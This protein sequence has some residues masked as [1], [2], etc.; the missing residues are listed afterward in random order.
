MNDGGSAVL[1]NGAFE[2][3][4]G[5]VTLSTNGVVFL[6]S[7][8]PVAASDRLEKA[9]FCWPYLEGRWI[10]G[11]QTKSGAASL[12]W[13][14]SILHGG[15]VGEAEMGQ[16]LEECA[17]TPPGS[18]GVLFLPYLMGQGTPADDPEARGAFTGLTLSTDRSDLTRA[19][20]EGVAFSLR[21]VLQELER[22]ISKIDRLSITG[23]GARSRLWRQIVADVLDRTLGYS[24]ADSCLGA[25]MLAAAAVGEYADAGQAAR[26]M[27]RTPE[28]TRPQPD[29]ALTYRQVYAEYCQR[30]DAH[31][32]FHQT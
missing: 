30:R 2:N 27:L 10:L 3:G 24:Q 25:A 14:R 19:V 1:A 26:G 9:V 6:V 32:A 29:T 15:A 12:Q 28:E 20:L 7:E 5:I 16:L 8:A 23:G 31:L 22:H 4:E 18:H 11:G 13:L 17:G 21:D